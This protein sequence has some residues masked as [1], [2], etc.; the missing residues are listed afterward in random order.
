MVNLSTELGQAQEQER[1]IRLDRQSEFQH[2]VDGHLCAGTLKSRVF[3]VFSA[4]IP[5]GPGEGS[6]SDPVRFG[7]VAPSPMSA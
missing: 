2:E 5:Q 6:D 1:T 4:L 7:S 3:T